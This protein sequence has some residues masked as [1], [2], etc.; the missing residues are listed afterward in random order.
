[1]DV[2]YLICFRLYYLN[3]TAKTLGVGAKGKRNCIGS[4][5]TKKDGEYRWSRKCGILDISQPYRPSR[6][7]TGIVLLF[8]C[9]IV[10]RVP[11]YRPRGSGS[12][13]GTT[14]FSEK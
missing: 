8:I 9:G 4:I 3:Y 6:P 5:G 2:I 12:I 14:R 1:L 13:P 11:G 10:V 7:V